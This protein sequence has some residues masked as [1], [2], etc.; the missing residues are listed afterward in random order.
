MASIADLLS[1]TSESPY[2]AWN[3]GPEAAPY[4]KR[5]KY[6]AEALKGMQASGENIRSTPELGLKL[7]SQALLTYADKK[8]DRKLK[9]AQSRD[10]GAETKSMIDMLGGGTDAGTSGTTGYAE[11]DPTITPAPKRPEVT[12]TNLPP[13]R[14][15]SATPDRSK[16][17]LARILIGEAGREGDVGQQAVAQVI[18]NRADKSGMSIEDVITARK[19]FEPWGNPKTRQRLLQLDP[20]SPEYQ[21]ALMNADMVLN[22]QAQLPPEIATADHFYSPTAQSALGRQAPSWDNGKGQ[23]LGRHR[24][25]SL[26]Y[27]APP[28]YQPSAQMQMPQGAPPMPGDQMQ[29]PQPPMDMAQAP[30]PQLSMPEL[31]RPQQG[32]AQPYQVASN[33]A[34]PGPPTQN[35]RGPTQQEMQYIQ[36]LMASGDPRKVQAARGLFGKI[37]E[38]MMK[39]TEYDI[40]EV[41]GVPVY[42]DK[43]NPGAAPQVGQLPQGLGNRI[44][45]GA[46]AGIPGAPAGSR[47]SVSPLNE[48][49]QV[50]A[51]PDGFEVGQNGALQVRQGMGTRPL[52]DP[53][54]RA[55]FGIQPTDRNAYVVDAKGNLSKGA[56]N[57]YDAGRLQSIRQDIEKAPEVVA[58]NVVAPVWESMK[59]AYGRKTRAADLNLVYGMAKIMDPGSVVRE[60]EQ[61]LVNNTNSLP[62]WLVGQI[63]RLNGGAALQDDTRASLMAEAGSR[64]QQVH[65]NAQPK[66]RYYQE[67]ATRN[68]FDPRDVIPYIPDFKPWKPP[69]NMQNG[70]SGRNGPAG[71]AGSPGGGGARKP[72]QAPINEIMEEY[73]RRGLKPPGQR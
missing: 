67:F 50:Y 15:S 48:T 21:Q 39:P 46:D 27:N 41:N 25:F 62:D 55:R 61:V 5:S 56:D 1:T 29:A 11:A 72:A 8:N 73:R 17:L 45:S 12:M 28:G 37:Q 24:F 22:G 54:E 44:V 33:G 23:D 49:R 38:R 26:G 69:A 32:P 19:Q 65:A 43:N 57:P 35:P 36:S 71:G 7:L 63:N 18:K 51:P 10:L 64:V 31:A 40:K 58:V 68:G 42:Y 52:T 9:D 66:I 13:V 14:T 6:L 60:G 2:S 34:T 70:Q 47:F 53:A 4:V 3:T 30:A 59:D 20:Q 16:D